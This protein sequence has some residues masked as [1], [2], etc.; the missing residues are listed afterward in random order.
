MNLE[1]D[2]VSSKRTFEVEVSEQCADEIIEIYGY[3]SNVLKEKRIAR[4]MFVELRNKIINVKEN[5]DL[6]M[7]IGKVDKL[8]REYHRIVIK[9][10]VV[11]Y[12][13]DYEKKKVYI[14]RMLYGKRNYLY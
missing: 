5:P 14:S 8:Y 6:Y 3:I 10:Y 1:K 11:L 4:K 9:N 2:L 12:T 13:I 7:K